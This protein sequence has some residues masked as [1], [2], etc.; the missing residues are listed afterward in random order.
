[1]ISTLFWI[2]VGLF[3]GWNI[4]QPAFARSF[5]EKFIDG[6]VSWIKNKLF[7]NKQ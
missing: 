5:Q 2:A 7:V 6:S 1:M 3:I 4:P